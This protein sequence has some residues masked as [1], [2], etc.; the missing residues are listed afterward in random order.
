MKVLRALELDSIKTNKAYF[1]MRI[2]MSILVG[3]SY[4][5]DS[6]LVFKEPDQKIFWDNTKNSDVYFTNPNLYSFI[7]LIYIAIIIF[8]SISII[9]YIIDKKKIFKTSQ[10]KKNDRIIYLFIFISILIMWIPYF[11][12]FFPGGYYG[13][14]KDAILQAIG[15]DELTN[16]QP[17]VFTFIISVFFNISKT[18]TNEYELGYIT[19][20]SAQFVL[21]IAFI[22]YFIYWFYRKGIDKKII[23]I[24]TLFF[25]LFKLFPLYAV[26]I[27]KE[28]PFSLFIILLCIQI[29]DIILS[30][31]K[32]LEKKPFTISIII[33]VLLICFLRNN[34]LYIVIQQLFVLQ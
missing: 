34:G 7:L 18:I 19:L 25:G 8:I 12:S 1:S 24:L 15:R 29:A 33:N 9:G 13:D 11:L 22:T 16:H 27:W 21:M 26:S 23:I 17:I 28:T 5:L 20:G 3:I 10:N 6:I 4:F 14:V 31:G 30:K 2:I 32:K